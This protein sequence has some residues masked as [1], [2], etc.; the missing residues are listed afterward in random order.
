MYEEVYK[1]KKSKKKKLIVFIIVFA[2]L[3][4]IATV[5]FLLATF[6]QGQ[7]GNGASDVQS[8]QV[9]V[10]TISS[11]I[12]G[13]GNLS[14]SDS[15]PIR[16]PSGLVIDDILVQNGQAVSS[17][18]RIAT[19]TKASVARELLTIKESIESVESDIKNL[20]S[21]ASDTTTKEYLKK[22]VYNAELDELEK[23]E[24]LLQ[25][26]LETLTIV[27]PYSGTI[28]NLNIEEG[29]SVQE[30]AQ[31]SSDTSNSSSGSNSNTGGSNLGASGNIMPGMS[32]SGSENA[33]VTLLVANNSTSVNATLPLANSVSAFA[34]TPTSISELKDL[35]ITPPKAG[36]VPQKQIANT[37]S[38]TGSITWNNTNPTFNADTT[39]TAT[40]LLTA[41][42][43]FS[44]DKDI[45]VEIDNSL[46][47]NWQV[48]GDGNT[49]RLRIV[50]VFEKTASLGSASGG[51][52]Q[53]AGGN[54]Q[55]NSGSMM[56]SGSSQ[57]GG[58]S[59]S[60]G[61][62]DSGSSSD[63][64]L[65]SIATVGSTE[66]IKVEISVDE[67]DILTVQNNQKATVTLDAIE[68][69]VFEGIV[70]A[71]SSEAEGGDSV[72]FTV[73]V[74]LDKTENMLIGMSAAANIKINEVN[75]VLIIPVNALQESGDQV[76]VFT[77]VDGSGA[78]SGATEVK[79]GLSDG[80][81]VEI[82]EGLS[83]GNTV[84][85]TRVTGE[86]NEPQFGGFGG[87]GMMPVRDGGAQRLN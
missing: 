43:G 86:S 30:A 21:K 76:F 79:T 26:I 77:G 55:G 82:L 20:S 63:S 7:S 14:A 58:S 15:T 28:S 10:G 29:S 57:S 72:K 19:V 80:K 67:L 62:T 70:T 12:E 75:D 69:E 78:F 59:S 37:T 13:T 74:E 11:T 35:K 8:A 47:I 65:T 4:I 9:E 41:N 60:S 40:I 16:I 36:A 54:S 68:D 83:E 25:D 73:S 49:N 46:L 71:I 33:N 32:S 5:I 81:N 18:D 3:A 42:D 85:Y 2:A 66:K 17:G 87:G 53:G 61:T 39:Y 27:S 45:L 24:S 84:Y 48:F 31:N 34:T 56:G 38:Y 22:L 23:N 6:G 64:M 52:N 1:L 44:F 51:N 50:A